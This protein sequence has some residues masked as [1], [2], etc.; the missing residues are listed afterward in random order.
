MNLGKGLEKNVIESRLH[1]NDSKSNF[2]ICNVQPKTRKVLKTDSNY[3]WLESRL[4]V[5]G[6]RPLIFSNI[7][8]WLHWRSNFFRSK[9]AK[10]LEPREVLKL[11]ES[12]QRFSNPPEN[13]LWI[14][15]SALWRDFD[16][17]HLSIT[18]L[19]QIH[20]TSFAN[21]FHATDSLV[22]PSQI[23]N[24]RDSN[25]LWNRPLHS[26]FKNLKLNSY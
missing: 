18:S 15:F 13:S 16:V 17:E 11:I 3:F 24:S 26:S 14:N 10:F 19:F 23:G 8:I 5:S 4:E 25:W 22:I 7:R 20:R 12:T 2:V 6:K 9:S 1:D 21:L